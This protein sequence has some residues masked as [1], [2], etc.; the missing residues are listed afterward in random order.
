MFRKHL[1]KWLHWCYLACFHQAQPKQRWNQ[2]INKKSLPSQ[3]RVRVVWMAMSIQQA[4]YFMA[5]TAHHPSL[6]YRLLITTDS[7]SCEF[8]LCHQ[9]WCSTKTL[10]PRKFWIAFTEAKTSNSLRVSQ[11]LFLDSNRVSLSMK[12]WLLN[13]LVIRAF[14]RQT[15][16]YHCNKDLSLHLSMCWMMSPSDPRVSNSR[17]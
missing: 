9:P 17:T 12:E 7:T 16:Q 8:Y 11:P 1:V 3:R 10:L 6:V 5:I 2:Q 15:A 14:S 4:L 13:G